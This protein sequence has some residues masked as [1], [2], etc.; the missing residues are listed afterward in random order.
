MAQIEDI[1]LAC[2]YRP[3]KAGEVGSRLFVVQLAVVTLAPPKQGEC[4]RLCV[5][6][7]VFQALREPVDGFVCV[8]D[9]VFLNA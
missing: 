5:A 2:P 8:A 1:G 9:V 7:A 3:Y 4:L 6:L